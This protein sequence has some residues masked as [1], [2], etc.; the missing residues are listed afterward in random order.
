M[1]CSDGTG[2]HIH[3]LI[4]LGRKIALADLVEELKKSSSKWIKAKGPEY[5]DFYWQSGYG[6]F[7]IGQSGVDDLTRYIGHQKEHHRTK[8]YQEE[9][10]LFLRKYGV[11]F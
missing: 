1:I 6:A 7:S 11:D 5:H 9:L 8:S 2:D 3:F 10:R 4:R